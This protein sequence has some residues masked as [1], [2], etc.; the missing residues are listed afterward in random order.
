MGTHKGERYFLAIGVLCVA[1]VAVVSVRSKAA[2]APQMPGQPPS[3]FLGAWCAQGDPAKQCSVSMNG[4]FLTFT[5]ESGSTSSAHYIGVDQN[6]V[7]ADQWGFVQGT[8][9]QDG[10]RINW[11]NGT[12]WARCSGGGGGGGRNYPNVDGTWYRGGDHSKSCYIRQKKRNLSL[13]NEQGDSGTGN[14]DGRW[15]LTTNWAGTT[16]HGTI[17]RDGNTI[18]WDNSTTWTR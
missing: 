17:S 12:Y 5:N 16:V 8:L 11:S 18:Y 13:T 3:R 4:L 14:T 1:I 7:S 9:S 2:S 10:T 15:H 6:V